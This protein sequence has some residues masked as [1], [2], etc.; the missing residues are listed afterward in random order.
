GGGEKP[1]SGRKDK[2]K[3]TS[4]AKAPGAQRTAAPRGPRSSAQPTAAIPALPADRAP[5]EFRDDEIDNFGNRADYVP[6][7][8]KP[9]GRGRRPGAPAG[10]G[11]GNPGNGGN[12]G[13]RQ[14]GG[15]GGQG[16][17]GR[18][19]GGGGRTRPPRDSFGSGRGDAL[20]EPAAQPARDKQPVIIHKGERL[21]TP[22]QLDELSRRP[23]GEKP[24]LLTRNRES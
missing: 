24:A 2:G 18:N 12:P 17:Q 19:G 3:E 23:R 9:Q 16:G 1:G 5:D 4:R 21:P 10:G 15:Q 22:E 8:N 6:V 14:G 20:R 13:K 11:N 7:Q